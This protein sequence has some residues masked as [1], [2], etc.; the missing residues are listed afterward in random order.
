ML[1]VTITSS[2]HSIP[3]KVSSSGSLH[4]TLTEGDISVRGEVSRRRKITTYLKNSAGSKDINNA[5][6][7]LATPALYYLGSSL[8]YETYVSAVAIV[9]ID[10][11]LSINKF[12]GI[13]ALPNGVDLYIEEAGYKTYI[14]Q[15]VKTSGELSLESGNPANNFTTLVNWSGTADAHIIYIPLYIDNP[16]YGI[17]I[18]KATTDNITLVV[19]DSLAGLDGGFVKVFGS[20]LY[21]NGEI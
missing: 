11:S 1:P 18:N 7:S 19:K 14:F 16:P 2:E 8:E 4:V 10:G 20:R 9:L 12:G 13:S 6:G 15:N 5:S 3:T 17:R 21:P